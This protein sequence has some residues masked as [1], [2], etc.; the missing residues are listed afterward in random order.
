VR[1]TCCVLKNFLA[2]FRWGSHEDSEQRKRQF[3][4]KSKHVHSVWLSYTMQRCLLGA[5]LRETSRTFK[6]RLRSMHKRHWNCQWEATLAGYNFPPELPDTQATA[7]SNKVSVAGHDNFVND[8][9][10]D[11]PRHLPLYV[12][13]LGSCPSYEPRGI[14]SVT[15]SSSSSPFISGT[16]TIEKK[17]STQTETHSESTKNISSWW[18][19]YRR[20]AAWLIARTAT[21][22]VH[23]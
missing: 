8:N 3:G 18:W 11:K 2:A 9:S 10:D 22:A 14:A 15:S 20:D 5:S 6:A 4:I 7:V 16:W 19:C 21:E 23:V 1:Q 17:N 12:N 13:S